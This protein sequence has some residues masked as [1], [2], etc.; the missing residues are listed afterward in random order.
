M[1]ALV[2]TICVCVFVRVFVYVCNYV[3]LEKIQEKDTKY[4]PNLDMMF[5]IKGNQNLHTKLLLS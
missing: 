4:T 2:C 5:F 3:M 1:V